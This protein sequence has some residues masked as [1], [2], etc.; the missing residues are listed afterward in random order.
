MTA[1]FASSA[2]ISAILS[3]KTHDGQ[4]GLEIGGE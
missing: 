3:Q 4:E 1:P 2:A